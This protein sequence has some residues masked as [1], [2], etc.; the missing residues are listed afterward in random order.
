MAA[1]RSFGDVLKALSA[2]K[3]GP[4]YAVLGEDDGLR[5]MAIAAIRRSVF[6]KA[7]EEQNVIAFGPADPAVAGSLPKVSDV[8][9]EART[10]SLFA[11]KKLVLVRGAGALLSPP[12]RGARA[13]DDEGA[14]KKGAPPFHAALL[15]F[16]K[17]PPDG[18]TL[19]L[20]TE[21]LD[22]RSA[23]HKAL[24][25]AGCIVQCPRMYDRL[26][27]ET[28]V[29]MRSPMGLYLAE[30]ARSRG[31]TLAPGA[32]ERMLELAAGQAGRL[33]H[34]LDKLA[35]YLGAE[36]RAVSAEDVEALA[37]SG[38]ASA[39]PAVL[40]ALSGRAAEALAAAEKLFARGL[41][42]FSGRIT[43]DEQGIA[44][45]VTAALTRKAFE[46]ERAILNGGR[47]VA[48]G[49]PP[50]PQVTRPVEDAARRLASRGA[51]ERVY[52]LLLAA[53]RELKGSSGRG[54]RAILEDLVIAISGAGATA[55][56]P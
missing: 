53:D 18:T 19:V 28:R 9:D 36:K 43:W 33:G 6:G 26:Y 35:Q 51:M 16:L 45:I 41:E 22:G 11:G 17:S 12:A 29:S 25:A 39:D 37:S 27:G 34:E 8:M 2:G 21:K 5:E 30:L 10:A 50:P 20:E 40:G 1:E 14:D 24:A 42:D 44:I 4:L 56:R 31:L 52:R 46:V 23:L 48:R 15:D 47:Y 54:P 38:A 3:P 7:G 13:S 55:A 49:K 32:G